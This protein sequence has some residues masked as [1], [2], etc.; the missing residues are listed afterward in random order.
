MKIYL[1]GK[2]GKKFG[3]KWDLNIKSPAEALR[4]IDA[5]K[6]GFFKYLASEECKDLKWRIFIDKKPIRSHKEIQ[7]QTLDKKEI[8]FFPKVRGKDE[9]GD[10]MMYGGIGIAAGWGFNALADWAGDGWLG[11]ILGWTGDLLV[12]IGTALLL[13]GAI[14][15]L[16]DDPEPPPTEP[17]GPSMK[18]T[19]SFIF[20]RPLNNTVQGAPVPLG[21]GRMRVGSTIISSSVMNCRRNAF[22]S[23]VGETIDKDGN[24]VGAVNVD[25]Y[26]ETD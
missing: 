21:Y 23:L 2:V 19:S 9:A 7:V 15:S 10:M 6:P 13:Q 26:S 24:T 11:S 16:M 14:G 25:Q 5:N 3:Q 4:A 8:H 17:Q 1:H 12:E 20:S 18:N 22:D